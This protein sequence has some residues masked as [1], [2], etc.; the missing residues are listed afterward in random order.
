M[1]FD[2]DKRKILFSVGL[3][4]YIFVV[5]YFPT[6]ILIFISANYQISLTCVKQK[7]N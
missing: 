5:T 2:I 3:L 1:Q 7:N 4:H 6:I